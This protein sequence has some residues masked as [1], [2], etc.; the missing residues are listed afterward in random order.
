MSGAEQHAITLRGRKTLEVTGVSSVE[1]FDV[2]EFA[3]VT[4][5]GPLQVRGNN[6]HMKHLDLDAGIVV[7]EGNVAS[8]EYVPERGKK[9][10]IAHRLFR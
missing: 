6:L 7:I 8:L 1:S 2:S 5:G 4:Q 9:K 10:R 3:L